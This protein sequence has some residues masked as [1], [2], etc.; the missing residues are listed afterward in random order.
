MGPF[1]QDTADELQLLGHTLKEVSSYGNMQAVYWD[2]ASQQ[3][4][5]AADPRG[6]GRAIVQP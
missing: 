1:S 2:Y 3:V 5:A 6:V 4:K